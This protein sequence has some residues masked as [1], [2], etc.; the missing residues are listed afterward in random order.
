MKKTNL[1]NIRID[2][3]L[4]GFCHTNEKELPTHEIIKRLWKHIRDNNLKVPK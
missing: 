2:E 4:N 3:T 1:P